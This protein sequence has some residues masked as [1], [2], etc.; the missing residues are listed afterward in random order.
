[1]LL[2]CR[3]FAQDLECLSP[4]FSCSPDVAVGYVGLERDHTTAKASSYYCKMP[5]MT[6]RMAICL[7]P[8]LATG[9]SASQAISLI[10]AQ[11]PQSIVMACVVAA[12]EG[13]ERVQKDHP[14]VEIVTAALDR[15]TER[16]EIHPPR[17]G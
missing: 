6:G 10:K 14:D 12:P 13:V 2:Q 15:W 8:M 5:D 16:S 9:G 3:S 17:A 7:D 1:M 11:G 4:H